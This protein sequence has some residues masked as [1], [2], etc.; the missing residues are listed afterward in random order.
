MGNYFSNLFII[1]ASRRSESRLRAGK[2]R[3]CSPTFNARLAQWQS[4]SFIHPVR[5]TPLER[6]RFCW[7]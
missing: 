4:D 5:F 2:P 6:C 1:P 3:A 7:R